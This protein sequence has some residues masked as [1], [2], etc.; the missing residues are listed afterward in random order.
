VNPIDFKVRDGNTFMT[1]TT[2]LLFQIP[3]DA[4]EKIEHAAQAATVRMLSRPAEPC[5]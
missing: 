5:N 3:A 1:W 2:T 4:F